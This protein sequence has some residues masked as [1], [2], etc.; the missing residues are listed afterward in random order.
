MVMLVHRFVELALLLNSSVD[1]AVDVRLVAIEQVSEVPSSG[2]AGQ[3]LGLFRRVRTA[4]LRLG[5][6]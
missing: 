3:R 4:S 6:R 5:T 2:V 1:Y